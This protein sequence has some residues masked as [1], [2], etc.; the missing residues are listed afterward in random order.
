[1]IVHHYNTYPGGGAAIAAQKLHKSLLEHGIESRYFFKSG[2]RDP[3]ADA[4]YS[5]FGPRHFPVTLPERLSNFLSGGR[6]RLKALNREKEYYLD[7]R[8]EVFD[9]FSFPRLYRP[10]PPVLGRL[11][12]DIIH[13]HWIADLID[14][15]S[16]FSAIPEDF[17]LVWTLHDMNP[18]TGGCHYDRGCG[19]YIDSCGNC[20]Q[21]NGNRHPDDVSRTN[22][23]LKRKALNG[24]NIHVV[25]D[26][27]WLESCARKSS[28]FE[29]A[30]S[31]QTIHYGVDTAVFKPL[32]GRTARK[33]L[34]IPERSFV[35]CFGAQSLSNRR[36]GQKELNEALRLLKG[37]SITLVVFGAG[38]LDKT[39]LPPHI[40][41]L[42]MGFV[43][44]PER[45]AGIYAL[46]D[47]FVIPSL[48]EAFGQTALEA[49]ACGI[50]VVGFD[51]GGIRDM[52][53]HS[54]TGLL[55]ET[56][57]AASL[58][59]QLGWLMENPKQRLEM[60]QNARN[61][62]LHE[63]S[64]EKQLRNYVALYNSVKR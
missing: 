57:T 1:M 52:V 29:N 40:Q 39:G 15:D 3:A 59:Q 56:V 28:I 31:I 46:A 30:R 17:P 44:T 23:K 49:M 25:A 12:P 41:T 32:D 5:A 48:Q 60:G 7:N 18:F 11:R 37:E 24:K 35:L 62:A 42:E 20:P 33:D 58:A 34:R 4:T 8:A 55:A 10:T 63:F 27:R 26:S 21:L 16:F 38:A 50:P 64:L 47:V 54:E 2:E 36:K 61:L 45:L 51:S 6:S 9:L 53:R 43:E 13:L 19:G 22:W 14:Y